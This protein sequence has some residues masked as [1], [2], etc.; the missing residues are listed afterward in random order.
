M[1]TRP[2]IMRPDSQASPFHHGERAV[3]SRLGVRSIEKWA[4]QVI[5]DYMPEQ[6]REFYQAQPFMIAA[7]R[8]ADRQP[9]V[10]MLV[11]DEGFV[12]SPDPQRLTL[13]ATPTPGDALEH[14][15]RDNADVGFLGI[16]PHTRRRNRVNGFVESNNDQGFTLRVAQTFGN[17]PQYITE[18]EG[19]R[20]EPVTDIPVQ[21]GDALSAAQQQWIANADTF[22]IGSGYRGDGDDASYGMDASHR[23]GEPGFV[24]VLSPKRIAF[25]DYSGNNHYN[26]IGNLVLDARV[27]LLFVDFASGSLLQIA[28]RA[29]IDWEPS[30]ALQNQGVRRTIYIDIEQTIELTGAIPLR[31]GT[32]ASAQR[33]LRLVD[34]I[35]ESED[36][37]SFIFEAEDGLPLPEFEPGQH[38]PID[39]E[40][41]GFDA[42]QRRTYSLSS[43]PQDSQYRVTVKR[44]ADG[45]V[46]R[47]LHDHI[48]P[49]AVINSRH[50]A[51]E[52]LLSCSECPLV[53]ISAGVGVTPMVSILRAVTQTPSDRPIWFI[54]GARDGD[55][56]P[57]AEEVRTIAA[58]NPNVQL[59]V[60]YSQPRPEDS[61]G[62]DY[63]GVGRVD[64]ALLAE[65]VE[66]PD[67]HYF[68][69][70][71]AAF[72]ADM[73]AG[74]AAKLVPTEQIHYE[75]FGPAS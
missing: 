12:G 40:I 2:E 48:E 17:C 3:Q 70:G 56:H 50:P 52:F 41:A 14:A 42:P 58:A 31:W 44:V 9:W 35:K 15:F 73:Q 38:L 62:P 46:S 68:M 16:Q 47:H 39:V 4:S 61:S 18:R 22:F 25:P 30:E 43:A 5:R 21:R 20:V 10:T 75:S 59:H 26:T 45:L 29:S 54:H 53:L 55:H 1:T 72:M 63:H 11:G 67:A 66:N 71:P 8:D 57:L 37:A 64:G 49:G 74:L 13:A 23:G 24:E 28:G 33:P 6:H 51:G 36:V 60:M 27:G 7:A 19:Q 32:D 69:C 65:Q 34:K